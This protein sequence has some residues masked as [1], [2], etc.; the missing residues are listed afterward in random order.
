MKLYHG[1]VHEFGTPDPE[2]G[3]ERTDFG[4]GFY[5]TD[6]ER[7]ADDWL[8]GADGKH[9]NVY[10]VTLAQIE[11]CVLRIRRY[12]GAS[13]EWAKFVY[14]NRKNRLRSNKYDIIIGPLADNALNKWFEKIDRSEITWEELAGKISLRRYNSLQYCFKSKKSVKLLE[15]ASRK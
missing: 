4:V 1:T 9:V 7:M 14:A 12:E 8:K 15:Y 2:M 5:T 6:S 3:R 11:S 10:E 13:V